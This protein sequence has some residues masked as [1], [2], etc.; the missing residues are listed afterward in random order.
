MKRIVNV[1]LSVLL[2]FMLVAWASACGEDETDTTST[3][4]LDE[5]VTTETTTD[6][7]GDGDGDGDG[8]GDDPFGS[9]ADLE[10]TVTVIVN[11]ETN[12]TWSQKDNNW[13]WQDPADPESYVIFNG[14]EGKLWVVNDK[15][16]ME[17]EQSGED[18]VYWTQSPAG[19]LGIYQMLP[20]G[21]ITDDKFEI[22]VPG[23][24]RI[25]IEL[26]GPEGLPSKFS[27]FD[28]SGTEEESII[29]EYTDVGNVSDDLFVLSSDVTIE[30]MP[31]MPEMPEGSMPEM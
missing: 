3:S 10:A 11:G 26:K 6:D 21:S 12:V 22:S 9:V 24:G 25:V 18:S 23:E 7:N 27:T 5:Q 8:E 13:R 19:M 30:A 16:A 17:S 2:C 28:A 14:D 29:F 15:V 31:E 20:G 4:P 1:I